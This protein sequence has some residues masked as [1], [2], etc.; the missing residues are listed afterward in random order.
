MDI[1]IDT[2]GACSCTNLPLTLT[3]ETIQIKGIGDHLMTAT[4]TKPA[5]LDLGAVVLN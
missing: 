3:N 4:R 1:L 5:R 2:G